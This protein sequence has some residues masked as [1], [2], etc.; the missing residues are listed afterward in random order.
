[1][2]ER[3][4]RGGV[5][6]SGE[7]IQKAKNWIASSQVLL[8]MTEATPWR[9]HLAQLGMV[10]LTLTPQTSR[11]AGAKRPAAWTL[12]DLS[13]TTTRGRGLRESGTDMSLHQPR[14][15]KAFKR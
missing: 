9:Q 8:A 4:P 1:V 6:A 2:Q 13:C 5:I 3:K 11:P 14:Q 15:A 10:N 7:A 12:Q